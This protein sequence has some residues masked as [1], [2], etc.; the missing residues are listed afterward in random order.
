MDCEMRQVEEE[1]SAVV[2]LR[3]SLDDLLCLAGEE[4]GGVVAKVSPGDAH[5]APE[6]VAPAV[7]E[8]RVSNS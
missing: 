1:W 4:V 5:V 8:D 3:V 7:L 6:V 2:P